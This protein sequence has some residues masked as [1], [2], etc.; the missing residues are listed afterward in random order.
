MIDGKRSLQVLFDVAEKP[1]CF[2]V[3]EK[4]SPFSQTESPFTGYPTIGCPQTAMVQI[5]IKT[6]AKISLPTYSL[7]FTMSPPSERLEQANLGTKIPIK[8]SPVAILTGVHFV[9]DFCGQSLF[10]C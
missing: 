5:T 3:W 4:G 10:E 6:R 2:S 9:N 8:L 1:V 7:F